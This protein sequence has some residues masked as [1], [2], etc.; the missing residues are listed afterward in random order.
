MCIPFLYIVYFIYIYSIYVK[1][2]RENTFT[3]TVDITFPDTSTNT[4]A[5]TFLP[6]RGTRAAALRGRLDPVFV[7][8]FVKGV[9]QYGRNILE[10]VKT[11]FRF[12]IFILSCIFIHKIYIIYIIHIYIYMYIY[13][14]MLDIKY[15]IYIYIYKRI[16]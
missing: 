4:F 6:W 2:S 1:T 12:L 3:N 10:L 5:N 13:I 11:C 16:Y 14:Y 7:K 8:M 15:Y 9:R